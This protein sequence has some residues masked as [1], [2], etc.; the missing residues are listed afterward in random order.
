[1]L[2]SILMANYRLYFIGADDHIV[3]AEVI[4]CPTDDDAIAAARVVCAEHPAVEVW[5]RARR[6][7]RVDASIS[8]SDSVS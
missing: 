4:D 3:K 7:Q 2:G 8:V 5:E 6:V 1:M